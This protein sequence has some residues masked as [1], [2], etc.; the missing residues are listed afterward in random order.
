MGYADPNWQD[1]VNELAPSLYRYFLG[2][3]AAAQASDLVQETLIRL[4]QKHRSG[5][6]RS[7][8]GSLKSYAFGIARFVRLEGLKDDPGFD[9]VEDESSLDIKGAEAPDHNDQVAHLRWAIRQLKPSEQEIILFMIDGELQIA[10][11]SQLIDMP[12]GTVKSHIHRAKE[13][14][15]EIMGDQR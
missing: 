1:A 10:E 12:I 15:R 11:I 4:V 13:N 9:L 8:Q 2:S 3:F 7:E 5:E 6:F 14:L